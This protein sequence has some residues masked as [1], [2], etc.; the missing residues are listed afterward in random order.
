M[1]YK[2]ARGVPDGAAIVQIGIS[3]DEARRASPSTTRWVEQSYPLI[4]P[5]KFSRADCQAWWDR[6]YPHVPLPSSSCVICPY[7][8]QAMW[9]K[10]KM[11]SP[12][13][14]EVAVDYDNRIREKYKQSTEQIFYLYKGF[15]PLDQVDFNE[16]QNDLD[17][18]EEI[19]C[20]GGCG[21]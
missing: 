9:R 16:N 4:D 5:L 17:F 18:G 13:D 15:Q 1:G 20:S 7:K 2:T 19:Y 6:N 8:T 3:T 10:M 12:E 14:W 21:L 11:E